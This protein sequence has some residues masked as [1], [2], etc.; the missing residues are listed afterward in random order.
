MEPL[1]VEK[2]EQ[3]DLPQKA[4]PEMEI[5]A[6][7]REARRAA[8]AP[9]RLTRKRAVLAAG[10][11]L[12]V[13]GIGGL[14]AGAYSALSGVGKRRSDI[15]I[16]HVEDLPEIKDGVVAVKPFAPLSPAQPIAAPSAAPR[17][18]LL[19][20]VPASPA[21]PLEL[22]PILSALPASQAA[23]PDPQPALVPAPDSGAPATT[24]SLA[25]PA[26]VPPLPPPAPPRSAMNEEPRPTRAATAMRRQP[27]RRIEASAEPAPAAAVPPEPKPEERTRLLGVPMPDLAQ[28]GRDIKDGVAS[29]GEA[30]LNLPKRF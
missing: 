10:V 26:V 7:T 15:R 20:P 27:A 30:V 6:E 5:P 21:R 8:A 23:A 14:S 16:G 2:P 18:G 25:E 1:A 3:G 19:S 17:V 4:A 24:A 28:T 13:L 29:L 11:T 9:A 12:G 22:R